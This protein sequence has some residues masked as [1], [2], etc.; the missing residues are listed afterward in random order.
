MPGMATKGERKPSASL[1]RKDKRLSEMQ[2]LEELEQRC[3]HPVSNTTTLG[4]LSGKSQMG[5]DGFC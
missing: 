3:K 5:L 1:A 2:E 4:M